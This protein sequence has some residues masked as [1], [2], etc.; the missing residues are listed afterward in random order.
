MKRMK[1][2]T[3]VESYKLQV[4]SHKL[5]VRNFQL[6]TFNFQLLHNR[7]NRRMRKT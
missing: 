4:E 6:S 2:P 1:P 7:R 5:Q 3:T